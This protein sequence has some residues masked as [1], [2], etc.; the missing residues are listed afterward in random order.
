MKVL[1]V[2]ACLVAVVAAHHKCGPLQRLK[3]KRQWAASYGHGTE[4]TELGHFIWAQLVILHMFTNEI[5]N[6]HI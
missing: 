2:I 3:V 4:R 6:L 5:T 1:F